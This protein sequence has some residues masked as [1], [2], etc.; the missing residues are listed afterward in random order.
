[1]KFWKFGSD[2]DDD[3]DDAQW[4]NIYGSLADN[5]LVAME[6]ASHLLLNSS[7]FVIKFRIHVCITN[8]EKRYSSVVQ[9]VRV[10][11]ILSSGSF[12]QM[13]TAA[14]NNSLHS[15]LSLAL[16]TRPLPLKLSL[17]S[18][19]LT[20]LALFTARLAFVPRTSS[21]L[22]LAQRARWSASYARAE[23]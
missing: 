21:S 14:T 11:Y 10:H 19:F 15:L 23:P 7:D 17:S 4:S 20:F 6:Q 9:S 5:F 1:M 16:S 12:F 18:S 2:D 8:A 22:Q 3:D 13:A